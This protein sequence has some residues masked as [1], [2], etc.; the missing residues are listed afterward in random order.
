MAENS[1]RDLQLHIAKDT[2][3]SPKQASGLEV[4]Y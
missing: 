1:Q 3:G 4:Q 2:A